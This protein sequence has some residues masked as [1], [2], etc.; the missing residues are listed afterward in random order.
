MCKS[1]E[2]NIYITLTG[3]VQNK[4]MILYY[5]ETKVKKPSQSINTMETNKIEESFK[6]IHDFIGCVKFLL[7]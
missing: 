4:N 5:T 1:I 7:C 3:S 6:H 2:I